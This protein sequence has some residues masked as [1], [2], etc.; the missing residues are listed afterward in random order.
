[1][2]SRRGFLS[3]V[4]LALPAAALAQDAGLSEGD[5]DQT[6][7]LQK[8]IDEAAAT[9]R[10]FV[11]PAGTFATRTLT[12]PDGTHLVGRP[13]RSVLASAD[14]APILRIDTANRVTIE[15]LGLDGLAAPL[16]EDAGLLLAR[17]VKDLRIDDCLIRNAGGEAIRLE[18]CGGRIERSTLT[19][20]SR[21]GL[22][23]LDS[24]GLSITGNTLANCLDNGVLVW[25]S[26]K[27]DDGTIIANNRI[28]DIGARARRDRA[29]W[30]CDQ[31]LSRRRSRRFG[32]PDSSLRLFRHP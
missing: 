20:A 26:A 17:D 22:F 1:M 7:R 4:L 25:R 24:T 11:I 6:A 13:G 32:Q 14:G 28:E 5:R 30:Q 15:G 9:G 29:I 27:G 19:S 12:I 8:A 21:A 31:S 10:P 23:A 2:L 16:P 3:G 18:R